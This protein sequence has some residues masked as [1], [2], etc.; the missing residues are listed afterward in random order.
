LA[1]LSWLDNRQV[2]WHELAERE[3]FWMRL[4]PMELAAALLPGKLGKII[5]EAM[6]GKLQRRFGRGRK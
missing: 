1:R 4:A 6:P 3:L 5:L 2:Q